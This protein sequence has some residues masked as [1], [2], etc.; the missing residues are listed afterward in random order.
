[1][2]DLKIDLKI[3]IFQILGFF[4]KKRKKCL[5]TFPKLKITF[6]ME[7][8]MSYKQLKIKKLPYWKNILYHNINYEKTLAIRKNWKKYIFLKNFLW[9][10]RMINDKTRIFF[11]HFYFIKKIILTLKI[12]KRIN[13]KIF[14]IK[15]THQ[16]IISF[17][18]KLSVILVW[19]GTC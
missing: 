11:F 19:T 6:F 9:S 18:L 5:I 4:E 17:S 16:K 7:Y 1:M 14:S 2:T 12:L 3:H 10:L 13:K 8:K 15:L